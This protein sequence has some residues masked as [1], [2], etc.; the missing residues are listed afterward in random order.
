MPVK[1]GAARGAGSTED[2]QE[3]ARRFS[4]TLLTFSY[5]T[6]DTHLDRVADDATGAFE[7]RY[8]D[9][10]GQL[11]KQLTDAKADSAGSVVDVAVSPP[12]DETARAVVTVQRTI[13]NDKA[14]E[15]QTTPAILELSLVKT[16][17]GWKIDNVGQ[18]QRVQ[19]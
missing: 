15:P 12:T 14:P 19:L 18:L 1:L 4:E 11:R 9:T 13:K 5:K 8:V 6:L 7:K 17:D 3:V 2:I 16:S 10:L